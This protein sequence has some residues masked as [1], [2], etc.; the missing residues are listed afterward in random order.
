MGGKILTFEMLEVHAVLVR[1]I[2]WTDAR[3]QY[4]C[5]KK[6]TDV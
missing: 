1:D 4:S 2:F 6:N 5:T 3:K